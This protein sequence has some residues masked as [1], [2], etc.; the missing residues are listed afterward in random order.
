MV[1]IRD[2]SCDDMIDA[3]SLPSVIHANAVVL[4]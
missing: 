3:M 4:N 1:T 2:V